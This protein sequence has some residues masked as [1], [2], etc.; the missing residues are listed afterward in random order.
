MSKTGHN[1]HIKILDIAKG[2]SII[3]MTLVHYPFTQGDNVYPNLS[4]LINDVLMIFVVPIFIFI[5]GYLM[6]D[7]S[8]F[9][10]FLFDKIDALIKPLI[11]FLFSIT[12]LNIIKYSITA[13][14]IGLHGIISPVNALLS[15]VIFGNLGFVNYALWFIV[16]L[17]WGLLALKG[18]III[19]DLKKPLKYVLLSI[20]VLLL[21]ILNRTSVTA[22]YVVYVPVFF[23][24]L[25]LGY[26]F[27][28][29]SDR[30]FNGI[31]FFYSNVMF[32][33]PILFSIGWFVLNKFKLRTDLDLFL[34]V[35]NYHYLLLLSIMGIF[36]VFFFCR[37]LEKI[38]YLNT[39]LIEC[40]RASFF[41]LGLHIFILDVYRHIFDLKVY[42]P[43]LHFFLFGFNIFLCYII[44]R[45]LIQT[46]FIRLLFV[47]LKRIELSESEIRLLKF[48]PIN[49]LIPKE[50]LVLN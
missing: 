29:W 32:V 39:V 43:L 1:K 38:P 7:G 27:K 12:I 20:F 4:F 28:K 22:Y 40:S 47:P 35:F 41:I 9:K 48:K 15:V 25:G 10:A 30:Y 33:F 16:A 11:G 6:N 8:S 2:L 37:Y 19:W 46:P 23:T 31:S 17:F 26:I 5:S 18:G 49:R 50:I 3:L 13:D 36:S 42:D 34:F 45:I 24:F 14:S 44:Y 21:V